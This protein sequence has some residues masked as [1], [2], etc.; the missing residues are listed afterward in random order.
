MNIKEFTEKIQAALAVSLNREVELKETLKLNSIRRYGIVI[1][2]SEN[3]LSPVIY[4]EKLFEDF[5][6]GKSLNAVL[7]I[8]IDTVSYT[9][10]TLPTKRLV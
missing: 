8:I 6:N 4:L 2:E 5:Q 3:S 7:N 10:L 9:H 1:V